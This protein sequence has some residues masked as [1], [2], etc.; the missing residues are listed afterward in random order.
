MVQLSGVQRC[1]EA[2]SSCFA[3]LETSHLR[4]SV[5]HPVPFPLLSTLCLCPWRGRPKCV[6]QGSEGGL[7]SAWCLVGPPACSLSAFPSPGGP[8]WRESWSVDGLWIC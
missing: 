7:L 6:Q 4:F 8:G 2:S 1:R 3:S 5:L